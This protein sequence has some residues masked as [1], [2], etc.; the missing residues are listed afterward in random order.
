VIPPRE[1]LPQLARLVGTDAFV[2]RFGPPR[3]AEPENAAL[4]AFIE[5]RL[6]HIA[7]TLLEE[8]AASDDVIDAASAGAYLEDRLR[9]LSD[10][11]TAQ[12]AERLRAA[13]QE[14]TAGW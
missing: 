9:T 7:R 8:A 3:T 2:E 11:L 6:E 14:G 13:F 10:L 5:D 1:R 12:Q 4:R